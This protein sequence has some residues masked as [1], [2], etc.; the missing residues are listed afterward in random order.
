M[1]L[2]NI[3]PLGDL[4]IPALGIEVAAG[5][6]FTASDEDGQ[7]LLEQPS[8][9]ELVVKPTGKTKPDPS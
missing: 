3:S 4:V 9:Y 1:D 7:R 2:R 6:V 8:N 5:D